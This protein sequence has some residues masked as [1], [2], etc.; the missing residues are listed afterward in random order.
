MN[1]KITQVLKELREFGLAN[2]VPNITDEN[3]EFLMNLVKENN[4]KNMLEIWTANGFS[5]IC[6]ASVLSEQYWH[7]TSIEFSSLSHEQAIKNIENAWLQDNVTLVLWQALDIIPTLEDDS[8]DFIFIDGMKR[9]SKDFLELSWPKA[10]SWAI[11]V[12]DD[13]I[14]FKH[15]MISLYEYLEEKGIWYEVLKI[16]ADDGIMIIR[17]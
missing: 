11:I 7:I 17:K 13:V 5:A 1:Q 12:I 9:R 16:D 10:K 4:I 8:F 15:K 3:A 2:E 6:F 14:K